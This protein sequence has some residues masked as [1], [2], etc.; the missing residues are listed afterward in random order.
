V[1]ENEYSVPTWWPAERA[2]QPRARRAIGGNGVPEID[3]PRWQPPVISPAI[4]PSQGIATMLGDDGAQSRELLDMLDD[5]LAIPA[6]WIEVDEPKQGPGWIEAR[7]RG[8]FAWGDT[9]IGRVE[10]DEQPVETPEPVALPV[11]PGAPLEQQVIPSFFTAKVIETKVVELA[12]GVSQL[13]ATPRAP[14]LPSVSMSADFD[15]TNVLHVEDDPDVDPLTP[16]VLI[17]E[18]IPWATVARAA[19]A[20]VVTVT[21]AI[22]AVTAWRQRSSSARSDVAR[23][24]VATFLSTGTTHASVVYKTGSSLIRGEVTATKAPITQ[25]FTASI[26]V[27]GNQVAPPIRIETIWLGTDLYLRSSLMPGGEQGDWIALRTASSS[28]MRSR[29][30]LAELVGA[31]VADPL[32]GL[33]VVSRFGSVSGAGRPEEVVG[34]TTTRYTVIVDSAAVRNSDDA[35]AK[36]IVAMLG[37]NGTIELAVWIENG[38]LVQVEM[39]YTAFGKRGTVAVQPKDVGQSEPIVAPDKSVDAAAVRELGAILDNAVR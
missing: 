4:L 15:I 1:A 29:V 11:V 5:E 8:G 33:R 19:I 38:K 14:Q 16:R 22:V 9:T 2:A 31:P 36:S 13:P 10:S 25:R 17:H 26:P 39:P 18:R 24:A 7:G 35:E 6:T 12:R 20:S 37:W 3:L 28:D 27:E 23:S 34:R 30:E 21:L 32:V